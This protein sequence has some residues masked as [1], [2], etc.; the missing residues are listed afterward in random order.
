MRK[1]RLVPDEPF[2]N[3]VDVTVYDVTEG[4]EKKRAVIKLEYARVDVESFQ[5][6]GLTLD[7]VMIKYAERLDLL[8]KVYLAGEYEI[9]E[10][11]D[12][13]MEILRENLSR[14]FK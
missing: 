5:K 10:G 7:Q 13:V 4:K 14:Y 8:L 1:I 9:T 2:Y 3:D 12:Q 11:R 6:Q